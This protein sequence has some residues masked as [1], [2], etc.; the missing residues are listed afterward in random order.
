MRRFQDR[1]AVVTGAASGI[2]RALCEALAA[3]GADL[4]LVDL[5][6]EGMAETARRVEATGRRASLHRL[7]VSDAAR[8]QRLPDEVLAVHRAVHLLVNNAGVSVTASF[9]EQSLEDWE[10]I[11]GINFWGVVYG[12]RSFLPHLRAQDEA[13]IVNISSL[14]GLVGIPTQS[15][16]CATKFAVRGLSESLWVELAGG[17]VGVTCVHPGGVRTRIVRSSRT[18]DVQ[19]KG[20]LEEFFEKRAMPPERAARAIL[21]AVERRRLRVR[22]G[23]ESYVGDWIKR[24][25]PELGQRLVAWG[26]GRRDAA[27]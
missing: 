19:M 3:R 10:W 13:H 18:A 22:I 7:D 12:C 11:V 24:A 15:S 16:Y 27:R 17:P 6:E 26:W 9:E 21:R 5:D 23:P 20:Q 25:A 4:A 1:V 14:F 8:M 2:G